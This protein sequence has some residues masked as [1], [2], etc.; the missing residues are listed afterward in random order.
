MFELK[1]LDNSVQMR[2]RMQL[3]K[4]TANGN[5]GFVRIVLWCSGQQLPPWERKHI[6]AVDEIDERK[7]LS[8][9]IPKTED[10]QRFQCVVR[11]SKNWTKWFIFFL[12]LIIFCHLMF[13][14]KL[15]HDSNKNTQIQYK[16][17]QNKMANDAGRLGVKRGMLWCDNRLNFTS[18]KGT[19]DTDANTKT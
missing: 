13:N 5:E 19:S 18:C 14:F 15:H 3:G 1:H 4:S 6:I 12:Q 11:E 9:V 16:S 17:K 2:S 7:K 8:S 10:H